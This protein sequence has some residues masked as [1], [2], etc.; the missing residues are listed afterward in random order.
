MAILVDTLL[1]HL[2]GLLIDGR[3][4]NVLVHILCSP[5]FYFELVCDWLTTR[6]VPNG[7]DTPSAY[8]LH[9]FSTKNSVEATTVA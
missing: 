8:H 5:L 1:R 3:Q 9:H 2:G 4:S 6:F 7:C